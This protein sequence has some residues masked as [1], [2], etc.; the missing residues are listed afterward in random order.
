M[1]V[2]GGKNSIQTSSEHDQTKNSTSVLSIPKGNLN[3]I[4]NR[5]LYNDSMKSN[6]P[7]PFKEQANDLYTK[8]H[9]NIY[10]MCLSKS[11][12]LL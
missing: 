11:S 8:Y 10:L 6:L 12:N 5:E 3:L 4:Y 1:A 9:V 2:F 7:N